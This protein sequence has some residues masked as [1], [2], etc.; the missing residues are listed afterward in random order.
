MTARTWLYSQLT[1]LTTDGVGSRVF[2]KKSMSSAIEQHP[3]IVYKLGQNSPENLTEVGDPSR[4]FFQV[5]VHDFADTETG[6]YVRIDRVLKEI[7]DTLV[8]KSSKEDGV[9][10]VRFLET[11]QDLDD[12]TLSTVMKYMRL[13]LIL[14][15]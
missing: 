7:K 12:L 11:S 2:A 8:N 3:F 13:Q 4:Q 15:E 1:T 14:E 10:T 5:F 9:I 6:D